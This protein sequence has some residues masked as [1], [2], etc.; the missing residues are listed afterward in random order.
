MDRQTIK[1]A[2]EKNEMYKL[3]WD[4]IYDNKVIED[5]IS[6][7]ESAM[8]KYPNSDIDDTIED[9]F[10]DRLCEYIEDEFVNEYLL[11]RGRHE[12]LIKTARD[13]IF[14]MIRNGTTYNEAM[15][16]VYRDFDYGT[17]VFNT[18]QWRYYDEE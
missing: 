14:N 8:N 11:D 15:G 16:D 18:E 1:Q 4:V 6:A 12:E 5:T 3:S 10:P 7:A 13:T 9:I 17:G 2:L